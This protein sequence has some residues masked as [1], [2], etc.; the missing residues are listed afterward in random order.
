VLTEQVSLSWNF[1]FNIVL[2]TNMIFGVIGMTTRQKL[3]GIFF[4]FIF[5]IVMIAFILTTID[6]TSPVRVPE[7]GTVP[8]EGTYY[9]YVVIENKRAKTL[10][11]VKIGNA[12]ISE[13]YAI[14]GVRERLPEVW[15]KQEKLKL[16]LKLES[17]MEYHIILS[18]K[19]NELFEQLDKYGVDIYFND[20]SYSVNKQ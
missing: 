7:W 6:N 16:P 1:V 18:S 9:V 20:Y 11:N 2:T 17:N 5:V 10:D 15:E 8:Y 12:S 3:L 19:D 13:Q 14:K 4:S